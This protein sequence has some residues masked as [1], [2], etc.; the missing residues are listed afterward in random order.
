MDVI[1][2]LA[3]LALVTVALSLYW[4]PSIVGYFRHTPS[5][6]SVVVTNAL[7]GWTVVG[8]LVSLSMAMR[9]AADR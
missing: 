2:V 7:L 8:W 6:V 5:L 3:T 4:L 9:P 1:V